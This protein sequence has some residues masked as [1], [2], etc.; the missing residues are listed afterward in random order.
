M[1]DYYNYYYVILLTTFRVSKVTGTL[2]DWL[3]LA[4]KIRRFVIPMPN[5]FN[6][7]DVSNVNLNTVANAEKDFSEMDTRVKVSCSNIFDVSQ[8][9]Q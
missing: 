1:L 8:N 5:A 9:V 4:G 6:C 2:V 3:F 7:P